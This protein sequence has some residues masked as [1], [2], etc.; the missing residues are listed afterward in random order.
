MGGVVHPD[1]GAVLERKRE[2]LNA[3]FAHVRRTNRGLDSE[4]FVEFLK[5]CV[6]P[7]VV[8]AVA[9]EQPEAC[10]D[11]LTVALYDVALELVAAELAGPSGRYPVI[12]RLWRELLPPAVRLFEQK[13]RDVLA[14]LTNAVVN[15]SLEPGVDA[16]G[17][18]D[19]ML[20]VEPHVTTPEELLAIGQVLAWREGM[21]HYRETALSKI[22]QLAPELVRLAFGDVE[23][24]GRWADAGGELRVVRHVGDFRGLGGT[25][26]SPPDVI[27]SDGSLFAFDQEACYSVHVDRFGAVLKR[28][29]REL[30]VANAAEARFRHDG[31]TITVEGVAGEFVVPPG[32]SSVACGDEM[33]LVALEHSHR[34]LV[35]APAN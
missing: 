9:A 3:R 32:A 31:K 5:V 17:W 15:L 18:L 12:S 16:Q 14:A 1:F 6:E 29:A 24:A 28:Y 2:H 30:P 11:R 21:A 34:I 13:P 25:F 7:T 20:D 26:E 35:I 19:A 27:Q 23:P 10:V 4:M 33:A 8:A 22:P